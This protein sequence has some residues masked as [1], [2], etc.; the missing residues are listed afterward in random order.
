VVV[1]LCVPVAGAASG[2][3]KAGTSGDDDLQ[4]TA[5]SDVLCGK[6]GADYAKGLGAADIIKGG[7]GSDT[8][9]GDDGADILRGG[10]GNDDLFGTDGSPNDQLFGGPGLRDRC[11]G[12]VGDEFGAC[13]HIV[14]VS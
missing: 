12:D 11:Y 4:G 9:V 13:E 5:H 8:L 10:G 2:C 3:T 7:P 1:A 6:G 14:R